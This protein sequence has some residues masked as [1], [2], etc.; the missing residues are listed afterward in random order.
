MEQAGG[1][2]KSF[3]VFAQQNIRALLLGGCG[4]K[5]CQRVVFLIRYRDTFRRTTQAPDDYDLIEYFN[6][7]ERWPLPAYRYMV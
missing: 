2:G 3:P 5:L 4:K 1:S 7:E 6:G